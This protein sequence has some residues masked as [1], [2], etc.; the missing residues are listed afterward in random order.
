MSSSDNSAKNKRQQYIK[1]PWK[2]NFRKFPKQVEQKIKDFE[3]DNI[4]VACSKKISM[5]KI[6]SGLYHHLG[7]YIKGDTLIFKDKLVPTTRIGKYSKRNVNGRIIIRYDLPKITKTYTMTVPN[8]GDW[9]NG[10][11]DINIDREVYVREFEPPK[12]IEM[13]IELL[14]QDDR[15][16]NFILKFSIDQ[17]FDKYDEDFEEDIFYSLNILQENI[18]S[19]DVFP[20]DAKKADFLR[21]QFVEWEILPPGEEDL[22]IILSKVKNPSEK[23]T[24]IITE[25]LSVLKKLE[26]IEMIYGVSGLH[27]YFGAKFAENLVV[28]ENLEYG[29]AIY[30]MF[31]NWKKL[32]KLSRKQLLKMKNRNFERIEHRSNWQKKLEK[33]ILENK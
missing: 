22:K 25:R 32:S 33:V 11:H 28:F 31:D 27:R 8:W 9:S 30:I 1:K 18:G 20:A 26:P 6:Q 4:Q 14:H 24:K 7:I 10:E 29:N 12:D 3:D 19:C 15:V 16:E 23:I 21:T 2:K 17:V 5:N 13:N